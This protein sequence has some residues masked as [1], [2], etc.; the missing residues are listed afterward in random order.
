MQDGTAARAILIGEPL[1]ELSPEGGDL[2]RRRLGGDTL[3]TA[4]Y[5]A[6]LWQ[7]PVRYLTRLGDCAQ[8]DWIVERMR[9]EGIDFSCIPQV[10]GKRPGLYVITTDAAGERSFT[11][12]R[13]DSPARGLFESDANPDEALDGAALVYV[14]GITLAVIGAEA[15]TRLI[16]A[17]ARAA[18]QGAIVGFDPNHRPILWESPE[19]ARETNRAAM[20]AANLLLPSQEDLGLLGLAGQDPME[21]LELLHALGSARIV[22]KTGGG[23]VWVSEAGEVGTIDPGPPVAAVDTTGAG[24]SFNAGLL[25]A[26]LAGADLG[27]AVARGHALASRVVTLPGA[28]IPAEAMADL[29]AEARR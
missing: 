7:G 8:S 19:A 18:G 26:L 16:G 29:M 11:Y 9:A 6:R 13:A 2:F 10:A 22:L 1:I 20:Q 25:A 15:R 17:M 14:S 12:W 21:T 28:V 27:T 3:N 5:L 23:P 4:T 24:D